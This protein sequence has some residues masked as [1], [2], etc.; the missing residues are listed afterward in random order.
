MKICLLFGIFP[1][2]N[3]D[4]IY[5]QSKGGMQNAAD[6]LQK[7]FIAGFA[8]CSADTTILNTPFI[9]SY[10][11]NYRSAFSI[12]NEFCENTVKG[13]NI[14][15]FNGTVVKQHFIYTSVKH[16][17]EKYLKANI[18]N[19]ITVVVY[20]L[21]PPLLKACKA[22]TNKFRFKVIAIVPDLYEY[23]SMN[24]NRIRYI[25]KKYNL[26]ELTKL[27]PIIDGYVL[28]TEHMAERLPIDGKPY[29]VIEGIYN[30]SDANDRP[31]YST[32]PTK[33]ILYTGALSSLYGLPNLVEAF[34]L[35]DD[36]NA[37]LIICGG[38]AD[39][40][41][42]N[43]IEEV[44]SLDSRII[45]KGMLPRKEVLKLQRQATLLVNP[46]TS[47]GI[48]TKYSFPSKTMEYLASGTPTLLYQLPGIPQE[49][50]N[51]CFCPKD[52]TIS[53][54]ADKMKEIIEMPEDYLNDFGKKAKDFILNHKNPKI[55]VEKVM[56]LISKL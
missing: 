38:N 50:Y 48:F 14:K 53:S 7:A 25:L 21:Y 39:D 3:Y 42:R 9:G 47:E 35:I 23:T 46:R 28:L 12:G 30:P 5:A 29:T 34:K 41:M 6:T 33:S 18:G 54:L 20:S 24:N 17:L 26:H 2:A 16:A 8:S 22:L 37:R 4:E 11:K 45:F 49:H 56:N 1:T 27:Y 55:Q 36:N 40:K 44:Q 32:K 52:E 19:A 15:F 31:I 51:Y 43:I 13:K 10:P